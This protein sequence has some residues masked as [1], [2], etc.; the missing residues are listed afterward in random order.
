MIHSTAG[1]RIGSC[2]I[3]SAV[4]LLLLFAAATVLAQRPEP[5]NATAFALAETEVADPFLA[6]VVGLLHHDAETS[7]DGPSLRH[8]FPQLAEIADIPFQSIRRFSRAVV[9]GS[10]QRVFEAV[11]TSDLEIP[12]PIE[13][14]GY[15]PGRVRLGQRIVGL[16]RVVPKLSLIHPQR[17]AATII[18]PIY[19]VDLRQGG[20]KID[21]DWWLDLLLGRD[22]GDLDARLVLI[23][24]FGRTWLGV[25]GGYGNDGRVLSWTVDLRRSAFLVNPPTVLRGLAKRFL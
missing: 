8:L 19:V 24:Q 25:L 10:D 6:M 7:I 1:A 11:F 14:L 2:R 22:F 3:R 21:L 17:R 15:H 20:M 23:F 16:Q 12:V 18:G 9:P 4:T 13:I 5:A